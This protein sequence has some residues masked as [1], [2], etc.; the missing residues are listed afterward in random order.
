MAQTDTKRI[1]R[2]GVLTFLRNGFVSLASVLVITITLFVLGILIFFSAMMNTS[3]EQIKNK[4]DVDVYFTTSASEEAIVG[5]KKSLENL[6]EVKTVSYTSRD[7]ALA[8]FKERH[9][10]D[11]L[12]L[13]ALDELGEN[14][15][16]AS[17][18][19]LARETSQYESIALFLED[20]SARGGESEKIIDKVNYYQNKAAID[21]LTKIIAGA[22]TLG[23]V[24]VLVLAFIA[25]VITFN[26]I[27]LAIYT[28]RDEIGV[29]R[30]VGANKRYIHGPFIV[31]GFLYGIISTF[32]VL[33]LFFPIT[34]WL[35][36]AT[37]QFFGS[38]NIFDYYIK[39]L[40]QIALIIVLS[41]IF[42]GVFSSYFA[43]RRYISRKYLQS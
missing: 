22:Q 9:E 39:N 16:G 7:Q 27:R 3:L 23:L 41:G 33:I 43:V 20:Q 2:S 24:I 13:Q 6:P 42:L 4:V 34:W 14:P 8:Q 18:N 25:I 11:F 31:E 12:T 28:S 15:L 36:R 32:V 40:A 1:I 38:V 21:R 30:L 35:G 37:E 5:L 10:G 17:L 19:I 29:M 26:T